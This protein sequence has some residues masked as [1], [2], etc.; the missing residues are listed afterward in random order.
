[1]NFAAEPRA[2]RELVVAFLDLTFFTKDASHRAE[3]DVAE[4][5][6]AYYERVDEHTS[7][8]GGIVVKFIGDGAL[9]VFPPERADDAVVALVDLRRDVDRWLEREGWIS[10]L[11]VK[12][13]F[14]S[15]IAGEFGARAAKRFDVIGNVVNVAARLPRPF[16]VT[17]QV[18]R[19]LSP[20]TRKKLK[21][22]TPP[23]TYIPIDDRHA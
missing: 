15:V 14:G 18:F 10:R 9:L 7:R 20:E 21:K 8:A 23:I 6:D 2:E 12:A 13:H 11:S 3:V 19:L 22:H 4:M 16:H 17:P 1:M 5:I